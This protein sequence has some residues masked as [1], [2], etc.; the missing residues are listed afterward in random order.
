MPV[1]G[2][3]RF[4]GWVAGQDLRI[5]LA[6]AGTYVFFGSGPAAA[7]AAI[8]TLPPLLMVAFRGIVAG[9]LLIFAARRTGAPAMTAREWRGAAMIG[10]LILAGGA[11]AGSY[12]QLTVASGVA[13]VLSALLPL[14]AAIMGF[15]LFRERIPRRAIIG[16]VI[17]FSGVGLLLRPGAN[18]DPFGVSMII[19]SQC[20]WALG[21]ELAPRAGL[22][23][24][25]RLAA[26]AE[27]LCGGAALLVISLLI[28]DA[29][30]LRIGAVS[31]VSWCGLAWFVVIAIG[32][33]TAFGYL[34]QNVSPAIATTFS[35]VNPVI[36]VMLGHLLFG[37]PVTLRMVMATGVIVA[38]VC[39]IVSTKSEDKP[40]TRHPMTSGHGGGRRSSGSG[41]TTGA[42]ALDPR[43]AGTA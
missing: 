38:G 21:A 29:G 3:S 25:P 1:S 43:Q 11:G 41:L 10:V 19:G 13:G 5:P 23:E 18:L 20:A 22:P 17:G 28:G 34:S 32:G 9:S 16:L 2:F 14:L 36:A 26:G 15:V 33:F 30:R 35:Y 12:G 31:F 39:L 40:K 42:S 6:L 7:T 37:E 24:D 8:K 27:L 4:R